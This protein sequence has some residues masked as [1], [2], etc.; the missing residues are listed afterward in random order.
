VLVLNA[1]LLLLLLCALSQE[2]DVR[3]EQAIITDLVKFGMDRLV[4]IKRGGNSARR[5]T[6]KAAAAAT[7]TSHTAQSAP[8][9]TASSLNAATELSSDAAAQNAEQK[10]QQQLQQ[11]HGGVLEGGEAEP[12][13][14]IEA[15]QLHP[16]KV[17]HHCLKLASKLRV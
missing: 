14:Y 1:S 4:H 11:Q 16:I 9:A 13:L 8:L 10:Q 15:L 17:T 3:L 2:L 5:S 12:Y 7:S 6:A